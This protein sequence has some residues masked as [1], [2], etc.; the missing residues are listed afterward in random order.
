MSFLDTVSLDFVIG[1][2][3]L[4]EHSNEDI[5]LNDQLLL[6][7]GSLAVKGS[8]EVEIRVMSNLRARVVALDDEASRNLTETKL[9][10]HALGNTGSRFS[11][12]L[13]MSVLDGTS[14][15]DYS[16]VKLTVI[17][18][19]A[20]V[21][22]S[23]VVLAQFE[24]FLEEDSSADTV[25][26]IVETL[27]DG[28]EYIQQRNQDIE[29]YINTINSH[30]L[31]YSLAEA[32]SSINSTDLHAMMVQYLSKIR[33]DE[34]IF[35][36]I[37]GSAVSR[38]KRNTDDWDATNSDYNYVDS[39]V[40]RQNDVNTYNR[41]NAY[42]TAKTIGIDEANIKL[43]YGYFCGTNTHCD[44][45]KTY[46]RFIV[47]GK[48]LSHTSTL[49]DLKLSIVITSNSASVV[50]LAKIKSNTLVDYSFNEQL[51]S[52]C[53]N[54]NRNLAQFN[55]RLLTLTY[56]LYVYI[57]YLTLNADLDISF[58]LDVNAEVCIGTS[59]TDP[60]EAEGALTP[61][62]GVTVSGGVSG[63]ILVIKNIHA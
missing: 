52:R 13:I 62:V 44:R 53:L 25:D 26:A 39:L 36:L 8:E 6:V 1:Y 42:I 46:G 58:D 5:M 20:K 61:T 10:L 21:T 56:N 33:A 55:A 50:V 63:N 49:A 30:T 14:M 23:P 19:M 17:E 7:F 11:I 43:A 51:S 40:N 54:Y 34:A 18:A 37:Y 15:E 35:D 59:G 22:D 29:E 24:S 48:L 16:E 4:F 3:E 47:V 9:L 38:G 45:F 12:S 32:V 60:S 57:G 28:F 2:E 31:V 27:H 41:H